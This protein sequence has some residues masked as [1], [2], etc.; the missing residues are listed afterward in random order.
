MLGVQTTGIELYK[1]DRISSVQKPRGGK[2]KKKEKIKT[3]ITCF[4]LEGG[5]LIFFF[6]LLLYIL[7][8]VTTYNQI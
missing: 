3:N 4:S 5:F 8:Y 7:L 2:K 1:V 6:F